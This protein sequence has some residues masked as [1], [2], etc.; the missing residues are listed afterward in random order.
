MHDT[1]DYLHRD[2]VHRRWHHDQLTFRSIY[3][4]SEQFVLPLSHDEVVH[5]KGSLLAQ[6]Q[7]DALQRLANLRLLYGYQLAPARQEAAVHG[8]RVRPGRASGRTT[9]AS[10]GASSTSPATAGSPTLVGELNGAVPRRCRRCTATTSRTGASRG[11]TPT[12]AA[13]RASCAERHDGAG[14]HLG[15]RLQRD[16]RAARRA[17]GSGLPSTRRVDASMLAA[18]TSASAG[19]GHAVPRD[20]R[21]DA[22]AV[23]RPAAPARPRAAARSGL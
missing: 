17:T 4:R 22:V 21:R 1:L 3:A 8:R 7:G 18:T 20:G 9:R 19:R 23:A 12:T 16:A 2:P 14:Q 11:S 10:T 15:D 6:M 5:G 13:Q